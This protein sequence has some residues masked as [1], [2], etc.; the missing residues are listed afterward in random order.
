MDQAILLIDEI[1]K[2]ENTK[3]Y[4]QITAGILSNH[5]G[6][7]SWLETDLC[8][9]Y[10]TQIMKYAGWDVA[11]MIVAEGQFN[12]YFNSSENDNLCLDDYAFHSAFV[13]N[14]DE[15]DI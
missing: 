2:L 1:R 12:P 8:V 11:L 9:E 4:D 3:I 7:L 6:L 13:R 14:F 5:S 15:G 10:K